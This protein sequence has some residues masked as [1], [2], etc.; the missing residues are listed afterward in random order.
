MTR[1][2]FISAIAFLL[3]LTGRN[4]AQNFISAGQNTGNY[5]LSQDYEPDSSIYLDAGSNCFSIDIDRNGTADL[6]FGMGSLNN[7]P[8]E[9]TTW[10]TV[11]I[12][13]TQTRVCLSNPAENWINCL[14]ENDSITDNLVWSFVDD[15]VYYFQQYFY[16]T[17][18]PPSWDT[19]YGYFFSGYLGVRMDYPAETFYGWIETQAT[20]YTLTVKRSAIRG[21]TVGNEEVVSGTAEYLLSPNPCNGQLHFS[22]LPSQFKQLHYQILDLTGRKL[23][24]GTLED[25]SQF[26]EVHNL[27]PGNYF[28]LL[29]RDGQLL[30]KRKFIKSGN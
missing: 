12:L 3:L 29:S 9:L 6:L 7:L 30:A 11:R 14:A 27:A 22:G 4:E 23:M 8:M 15:S 1:K 26:I 28:L 19:T 17:Y 2:L 25:P 10:S 13:N 5:I 18:P 20:S 24:S 16:T 21:R